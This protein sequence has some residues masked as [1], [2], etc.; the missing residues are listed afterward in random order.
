MQVSFRQ[1]IIKR[2]T[3]LSAPD[4]L[5]KTSLTGASIDLVVTSDPTLIT[6]AHYHAD[7]LFEESKT[8][9]GAWGAGQPGSINGPLAATGQ[10]QYLFWDVNLETGNLSYGWTLVPPIISATEPTLPLNDTHWFDLATT[11]MRVYKQPDPST[12]GV[13]ID[14]V[15]LFAA[16]YDSSAIIIPFPI[17][18]QVGIDGGSYRAG[19][20][21]FGANNKPLKQSDGTFLTTESSLIIAQT[22]GQNVRFDT[23]LAFGQASEEI[24]KFHLVS[25][26]PDRTIG[27]A[28]SNNPNRFVSGIVVQD[29]H[30]EEVGQIISAG[31]IRNE[32]WNWAQ[33]DI[34]KP[35]FCGI[36]GEIRLSPSLV[37][38]V[39]QVGYVYDPQ[40]IYLNLFP[41]IR[42]R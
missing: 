29:L 32:Q 18:S 33:S 19:N 5:R 16:T 35:V 12:A 8:V 21:I 30:Q 22:S 10:T 26:K 11:R 20:L 42:L 41:P 40:S 24:P 2:Q 25:F 9:I 31:I 4:F 36:N 1:G 17:G 6:I 15:R 13:W 14:K 27:L 39:Q 38:V 3:A 7:Y 23:A 34:N 37:G 28:S